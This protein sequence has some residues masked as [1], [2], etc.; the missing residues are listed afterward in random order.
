MTIQSSST[1]F[2]G[3]QFAPG[4]DERLVR[5]KPALLALGLFLVA[6][7]IFWPVVDYGFVNYDDLDYVSANAQ[8]QKGLTWESVRWAFQTGHASNWHPLTW[9]SHILDCQLYG[10]KAGGHHLTKAFPT[11]L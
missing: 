5:M 8:V 2:V 11:I 3:G 10:L 9:L 6:V 4:P 1:Q 7:L